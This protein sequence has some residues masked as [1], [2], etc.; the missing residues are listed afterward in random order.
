MRA[1]EFIIEAAWDGMI[2]RLVRQYPEKVE[3]TKAVA[4]WARETLKKQDRIV[5]FLKQVE[6]SYKAGDDST[7]V[8]SRQLDH[9]MSIQYQPIQDYQFGNQTPDQVLTGLRA[10]ET[11]YKE[12]ARKADAVKVQPGDQIIK[13]WGNGM[14][15]IYTDRAFCPDEGRSGAHCGNV[16]GKTQTDQRIISLR[17]KGQVEVTF[18]LHADGKLGEMK[19]RHNTKPKASLH[20][21]ILWLLEQPFIKGIQGGGYAPSQNFSIRDLSQEQLAK[22]KQARP[23]LDVDSDLYKQALAIN[24]QNVSVVDEILKAI[25]GYLIDNVGETWFMPKDTHGNGNANSEEFVEWA[26]I[27]A[28]YEADDDATNVFK[29]DDIPRLMVSNLNTRMEWYNH[30][31]DTVPTETLEQMMEIVKQM[32][33]V[34]SVVPEHRKGSWTLSHDGERLK[35]GGFRF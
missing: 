20:P 22:L 3:W 31:E 30:D 21:Y 32:K 13:D 18:I 2:D 9:L 12:T 34:T 4:S 23:D 10:L 8:L 28:E 26:D 5:W 11:K 27:M 7:N 19:G 15:W 16:V 24:E 14:Q 33:V 6:K 29:L 1:I 25:D 17:H 35:T